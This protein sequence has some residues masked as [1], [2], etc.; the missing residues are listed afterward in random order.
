[1]T[2]CRASQ[3]AGLAFW[4]DGGWGVDVLLGGQTRPHSDLDLAV[5][6]EDLPAF[7]SVLASYGYMR[8]DREGDPAW[9][10]VLR[11]RHGRSVD[12]HGFVLDEGRNAILGDPADGAMYPAGS[13]EGMGELAGVTLPCVAAAYILL[14]RNS[15]EPRPVDHLDVQAL[16]ER[17]GL[18]RPSR[19]DLNAA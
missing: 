16:C 1:M 8:A 10:W 18:P 3:F 13:L 2:L 14:F 12:L 4:V 19:F 9:N 5:R 17:F 15:F 7:A 11:D 6:L